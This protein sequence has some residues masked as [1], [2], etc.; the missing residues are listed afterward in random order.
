MIMTFLK[1]I[2]LSLIVKSE[3]D[4]ANEEYTDTQ[5]TGFQNTMYDI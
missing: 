2:I 3:Q 1:V 4:W 5:K